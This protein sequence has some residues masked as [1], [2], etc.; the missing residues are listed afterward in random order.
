MSNEIKGI[1]NL[2][3]EERMEY[4]HSFVKALLETEKDPIALMSNISAAIK[5][6]VEDLNWA[7]FYL[8]QG[9]ELV[10]GPF[11]GLPA[12]TRLE[13]EVGVCAKA[14]REKRVVC[15]EDVH[16]VE[17]HV[18]CDSASNSELVIPLF[19][20]EEVYGVLDLDSPIKGRF[21]LIEVEGFSRLGSLI[22]DYLY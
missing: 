18:A 6:V 19:R 13:Y 16:A 22:Q 2:S 21:T 12:C 8:V 7:G 10:L 17:D 3:A 5:G 11:Q 14:W 1:Q 9:K 20:E 15:I 4:L